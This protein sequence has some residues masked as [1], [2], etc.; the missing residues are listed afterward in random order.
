MN[1]HIH[2]NGYNWFQQ[3]MPLAA[4]LQFLKS[5]CKFIYWIIRQGRRLTKRLWIGSP[6]CN[7]WLWENW[8]V[9]SSETH[10][11]PWDQSFTS[12]SWRKSH[13]TLGR[14]KLNWTEL[15]S[16]RLIRQYANKQSASQVTLSNLIEG[17]MA[18]TCKWAVDSG[19]MGTGH[20]W[21]NPNQT[22]LSQTNV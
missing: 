14:N 9:R 5:D 10:W 16:I 4:W 20:V 2:L 19:Y 18:D 11:V 22:K 7:L 1:L 3:L 8:W 6:K 15:K 12:T 21:I 17:G 13:C